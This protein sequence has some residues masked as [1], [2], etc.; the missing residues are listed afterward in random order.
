[1]F[2]CNLPSNQIR[3]IVKPLGALLHCC[4]G[5]PNIIELRA[6]QFTDETLSRLEQAGVRA[7]GETAEAKG[8][9]DPGGL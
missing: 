9:C 4:S 8:F 5:V 6:D 1:M 3:T 7:R 2:E